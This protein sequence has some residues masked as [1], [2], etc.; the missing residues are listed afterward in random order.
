MMALFVGEKVDFCEKGEQG[1]N[2][3]AI[4]PWADT[5]RRT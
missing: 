1:D 3:L 2:V 4:K 5:C